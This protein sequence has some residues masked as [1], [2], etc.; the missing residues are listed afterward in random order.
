MNLYFCKDSLCNI[1]FADRV[2]VY[3]YGTFYI[4]WGYQH[5]YFM[6]KLFC[7]YTNVIFTK[8]I[9]SE[10]NVNDDQTN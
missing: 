1:R 10:E 5:Q 8:K 6:R 7:I 4:I 9:Q 3:V 2:C